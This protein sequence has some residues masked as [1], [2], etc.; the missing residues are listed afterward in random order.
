MIDRVI[1]EQFVMLAT[2][3]DYRDDVLNG[4][5]ASE[6]T[7]RLREKWVRLELKVGRMV[8][9]EEVWKQHRDNR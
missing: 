6:R 4:S 1:L 9:V 2:A 7:R 8:S 3:L 5:Q